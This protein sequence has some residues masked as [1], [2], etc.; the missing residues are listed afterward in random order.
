MHFGRIA[1]G[2]FRYIDFSY[3]DPHSLLKTP[4]KA[5]LRGEDFKEGA[6]EGFQEFAE[7]FAGEEILFG[8]FSDVWNNWTGTRKVYN[9]QDDIDSQAKDVMA[10]IW[11]A[12]E[13]GI[14]TSLGRIK[15][16]ITRE[17]SPTGRQYNP[18]VEAIALLTGQ[19][20]QE[21]DVGQSLAWRARDFKDDLSEVN[22]LFR[23]VVTRKGHVSREEI[24]DSYVK[25]ERIRR[26]I[27]KDMEQTSLAAIRLGLDSGE[28]ETIL[29]GKG[30][31][32][33]DLGG[34]IYGDYPRYDISKQTWA[35]IDNANPE[36]YELRESAIL[37]AILQAE[38]F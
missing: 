4:V 20:I 23:S 1:T 8:K 7:P 6:W 37:E 30:L 9:E 18:T 19:R 2:K 25:M 28:V 26:E 17:V 24:I 32:N 3:S 38:E 33:K 5:F 12:F 11:E 13:P 29:K 14:V 31:S 16:G 22:S 35:A 15:K 36:E 21:L 27:F 10:H 34:V